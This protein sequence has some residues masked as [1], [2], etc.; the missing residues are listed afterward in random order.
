MW[1]AEATC[2]T[3]LQVSVG[4]ASRRL[5]HVSVWVKVRGEGVGWMRGGAG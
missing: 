5:Q 4:S 1:S 3:S 2:V